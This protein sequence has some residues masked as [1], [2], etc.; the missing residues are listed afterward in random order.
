MPGG[1]LKALGFSAGFVGAQAVT[2]SVFV[3][4]GVAA[5]GSGS[6]SHPGV[7]AVLALALAVALIALAFK[8][9]RRPPKMNELASNT[10]RGAR[11]QALVERLGR[12][13]FLTTFV[14]GFVLGVGGP[15]R[16]VVTSLAATTIATAG[17]GDADEAVLSVVYVALATALVWGPTLFFLLFGERVIALME[18]LEGEVARRQ[19]QI[20]V[21]ALLAL[22]GLLVVDAI[23]VL[24][25][26]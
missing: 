3:T 11:T 24:L 26:S 10:S 17:A 2:C 18:G 7:R 1:R 15:K 13:H 19:P 22:A 14:A 21:Y 5:A 20:T 12:L 25:T 8:V 9:R 6:K 16:L 23:G 4:I